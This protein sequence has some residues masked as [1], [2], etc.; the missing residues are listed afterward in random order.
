MNG[1]TGHLLDEFPYVRVGDG[2]RPLVIFPG[3]TDPL[4]DG[5]YPRIAGH[6][7]RRYYH[8][9]VDNYTVYVISRPRGLD[10][11]TTIR[12]M[13]DDYAW[14]IEAAFGSATVWGLSMG[15]CIA[16]Q[17]AVEH[18]N[19]VEELV[20][21]VAG[22]RLGEEGWKLTDEMRRRAY[23]HDWQSIRATIAA[24]MF[25]D[26]RRFVY[27]SMTASVG[28]LTL[29][30]PAVPADAWISLE[31]VLDYDGRRSVGGIE[32]RT[33]VIG[34]E[35]DPFFPPA[36]LEEAARAIPNARLHVIGNARHGVFHTHKPA[37]ER[38]VKSFLNGYERAS[39]Q[40]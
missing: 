31:A 29:P 22:T 37:F 12:D 21:G 4:F 6:L 13:A 10:A 16:Q 25:P 9:F 17:L 11:G 14:V 20:L 27:P 23:D 8:R 1:E 39:S 5:T 38:R 32:A 19:R 30:K 28:R 7:L 24:G 26:W 2:P 15:G 18:P 3:A 33:L 35:E 40:S 36:V 34:G